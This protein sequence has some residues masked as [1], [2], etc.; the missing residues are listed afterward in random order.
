MSETP[1]VIDDLNVY[2][3][4][5]KG[6]WSERGVIA[7]AYLEP[8]KDDS[9]RGFLLDVFSSRAAGPGKLGSR[10]AVIGKEL[11]EQL[12]EL[13]LAKM[14]AAGWSSNSTVEGKAVWKHQGAWSPPPMKTEIGAEQQ[15]TTRRTA[16]Y[17][18]TQRVYAWNMQDAPPP[19]EKQ[20]VR[21]TRLVQFTC[22]WCGQEVTEQR[23][24]SHT[25]L[26]CSNPECK[27]EANR[28]KIRERVAKHRK[29]HPDARKQQKEETPSEKSLPEH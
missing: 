10:Q 12:R 18:A 29:L 4:S 22:Q 27:R 17:P 15:H 2:A 11:E 13:L 26:Y 23:Y 5:Y 25:P 19:Q 21:T 3:Q 7:H 28:V 24:P 14:Q 9:R 1:A 8:I 20:I 16:T 6:T